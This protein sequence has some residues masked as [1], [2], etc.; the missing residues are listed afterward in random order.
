[1]QVKGGYER[2]NGAVN[3]DEGGTVPLSSWSEALMLA[4]AT[5]TATFAR[6][7]VIH[8]VTELQPGDV[9]TEIAGITIEGLAV[10]SEVA[11]ANADEW[12]SALIDT[13]NGETDK[14]TYGDISFSRPA[15]IARPVDQTY[16]ITG[17][18]TEAP[19]KEWPAW[20]RHVRLVLDGDVYAEAIL[21]DS[22]TEL[23]HVRLGH[24]VPP[25]LGMRRGSQF[26]APLAE[27]LSDA[28]R[29][30]GDEPFDFEVTIWSGAALDAGLVT[31]R[32]RASIG[33]DGHGQ[34]VHVSSIP[35]A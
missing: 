10:V 34:F 31:R 35:E 26:A 1:M 17:P 25:R 24:R 32:Y 2:G 11:P 21:W 20:C 7:G 3:L 28:I 19:L 8:S 9:L 27:A 15:H 30:G 18:H 16:E 5:A 23:S 14:I 22:L 4:T 29:Q 13:D 6:R 12:A 33:N